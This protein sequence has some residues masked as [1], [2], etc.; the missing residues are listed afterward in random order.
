MKLQQKA[1]VY[2]EYFWY[3]ISV[4]ICSLGKC[5]KKNFFRLQ[6][7]MKKENDNG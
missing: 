7:E 5:R 1:I 2:F 6:K 4:N 3:Y